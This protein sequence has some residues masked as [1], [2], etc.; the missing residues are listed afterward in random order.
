MIGIKGWQLDIADQMLNGV[1][2]ENDIVV[3]P[4]IISCAPAAFGVILSYFETIAK[5]R[6]GYAID[7]PGRSKEYFKQGFISCLTNRLEISNNGLLAINLDV[8][9]RRDGVLDI[10]Y[11]QARCGLYH[12][13]ML[14]EK[15]I[16]DNSYPWWLLV[17]SAKLFPGSNFLSHPLIMMVQPT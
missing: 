5:Y 11:A 1:K 8:L 4:P 7:N 9:T 12:G 14:R 15:I 6:D 17:L 2:D 3:G 10:I 13:S 16:L